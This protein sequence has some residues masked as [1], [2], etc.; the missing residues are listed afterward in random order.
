MLKVDL[1]IKFWS[2]K[3]LNCSWQVFD[4]SEIADLSSS[5]YKE[6]IQAKHLYTTPLN[7]LFEFD[8]RL[9]IEDSFVKL[10]NIFFSFTPTDRKLCRAILWIIFFCSIRHFSFVLFWEIFFLTNYVFHIGVFCQYSHMHII[11]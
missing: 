10:W 4:W 1:K 7:Y 6:T 5:F 3:Y 8:S 2:K 11:V 9:I